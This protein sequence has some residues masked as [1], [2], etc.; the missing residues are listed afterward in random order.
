MGTN[1][2]YYRPLAP[3]DVK[4]IDQTGRQI[5]ERVGI[6][7][8]DSTFLGRL[9]KAGAQ[10]DYDNQRVRFRGDWL[11]EVLGRAPSRFTLYSRDG[12]NDLHLG[13]GK[14]YFANG[15]RVFRILDMSTGGYRLTMLRD[16]AN[17]ATLVDHLDY[18]RFYIIACQVHDLGPQNYHLNDFYHAF[19][20][21][22]KHVMGGCDNLKGVKQMWEL[23]SLI[24]G[25][26][27][28]LREKPFVS[29]IT[30]PISPLTIE[31]NTLNIL[32]FCTTHGI[33]ATCASAPIAGATS[34]ATLAG[35]LSQM[36]AESLAG[37]A[38]T[39]VFAPGAK[40]LY[41]TVPMTIDLRDTELATG[42]V[43]MTMMNAAAVQLAKLYGLPIYASGGLTEA[44]RPDIQAGIEEGFSNLT[45]AMAGADCVHLAAGILDSG[46]SIAYEQFVIDNEIIGIIQR[47]LRGIKVDKETLGFDV[48]EKVGPGGHYILE[49]HTV[50]HMMDEFFYPN[51]SVRCNFDIWEERGRPDML[52]RANNLVNNILEEGKEGVLDLDL[53]FEIKKTFPGIQNI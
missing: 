33:P 25:G 10:V 14:V 46:N 52:S 15:G 45:V 23:A 36:H 42:S 34:P 16:V 27:G 48:I 20:H 11:D 51:L 18:I 28:K 21:T 6:R 31:A 43:E 3:E 24:A 40:V 29:V 49:D 22:T 50:E 37:V 38:I 39:Q 12:Q 35:T 5:L 1:L 17:T 47:L 32:N 9:K 7:I 30:N 4:Q 8:N 44:K 19:N 41:G 53:I 13:E 2:P 26:E